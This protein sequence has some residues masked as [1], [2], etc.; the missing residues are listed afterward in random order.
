MDKLYFYTRKM[1]SCLKNAYENLNELEEAYD[2][3]LG[4]DEFRQMVAH[5]LDSNTKADDCCNEFR[6][7]KKEDE[8]IMEE[9][10]SDVELDEEDLNE[11]NLEEDEEDDEEANLKEDKE[12]DALTLG[13]KVYQAWKKR[14]PKMQHDVAIAGWMLCPMEEVMADVKKNSTGM[15]R[16]AVE[17]VIDKWFCTDVSKKRVRHFFKRP[18]N[19][20]LLTL[21]YF[22][23]TK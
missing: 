22:A 1:E 19:Q 8:R 3:Q 15:H 16:L 2:L 6:V 17:R 9:E 18:A 4:R 21:Y 11:E 7:N 10:E 12:I 14:E 20:P 23:D 5:F 13:G